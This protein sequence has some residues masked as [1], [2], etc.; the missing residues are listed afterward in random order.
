MRT[1]SRN[2]RSSSGMCSSWSFVASP[3]SRRTISLI[4]MSHL[5]PVLLLLPL[6]ALPLVGAA[7][8]GRALRVRV[9]QDA[10]HVRQNT[11]QTAVLDRTLLEL[12]VVDVHRENRHH[13]S[14]ISPGDVDAEL[15]VRDT[16]P[17]EDRLAQRRE[18]LPQRAQVLNAARPDL[19]VPRVIRVAEL[20]VTLAE[21]ENA[22]V[23]CHHHEISPSTSSLALRGLDGTRTRV[24]RHIPGV[25]PL[26]YQ[27]WEGSPQGLPGTATRSPGRTVPRS[28][29]RGSGTRWPSCCC[30]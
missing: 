4:S 15:E 22:P 2:R 11:V 3:V 9:E 20:R 5:P 23:R 24:Y 30:R 16:H 17:Q 1:P 6:L 12:N 18:V 21:L 29:T 14:Q 28:A 13:L 8:V 26:N 7:S 10:P 27:P 25:L 19:H